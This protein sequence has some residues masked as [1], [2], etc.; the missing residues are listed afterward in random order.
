MLILL[1]L[2]KT[3]EDLP[4]IPKRKYLC[5]LEDQSTQSWY[6]SQ[7]RVT[8]LAGQGQTW[9]KKQCNEK[10]YLKR[11]VFDLSELFFLQVFYLYFLFNIMLIA[12]INIA[13]YIDHSYLL[14]INVFYMNTVNTG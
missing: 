13:N 2:F 11:N 7:A 10:V 9:N 6:S 3:N 4:N 1:A 8:A 5:L 14:C 12:K